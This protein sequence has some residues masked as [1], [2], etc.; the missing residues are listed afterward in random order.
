[1][2]QTMKP[3]ERS[4]KRH[5]YEPASL[6][7]SGLFTSKEFN[8]TKKRVRVQ[9]K[10]IKKIVS[11]SI[12]NEAVQILQLPKSMIHP[13]REKW[14]GSVD[15]KSKNPDYSTSFT[16]DQAAHMKTY[17]PGELWKILADAKD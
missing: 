16:N 10:R 1:M 14:I 9:K 11:N 7:N 8:S 2:S 4:R 3:Q 13:K 17:N 6:R 15:G 12:G 5:T